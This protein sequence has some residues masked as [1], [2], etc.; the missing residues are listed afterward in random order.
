MLWLIFFYF[1]AKAT[2]PL[3][4][5]NNNQNLELLIDC[6]MQKKECIPI[7]LQ[8]LAHKIQSPQELESIKALHVL[9]HLVNRCDYKFIQEVAK[10]RFL[11]ELIKVVSPKVKKIIFV[12]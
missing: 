1:S 9:E 4:N 12:H 7:T 11:N 5:D 3:S 2:N 8:F 10:F 6:L